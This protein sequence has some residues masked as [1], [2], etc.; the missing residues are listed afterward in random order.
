VCSVTFTAAVPSI[1][2]FR[3]TV[4]VDKTIPTISI[5]R[6]TLAITVAFAIKIAILTPVI[7]VTL[8][9][10]VITIPVHIPATAIPQPLP[11]AFIARPNVFPTI[12]VIVSSDFAACLGT[13]ALQLYVLG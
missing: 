13:F 11:T 1:I 5:A 3:L 9:T 6:A 2:S 10:I 8:S 4:P 12:D 7:H